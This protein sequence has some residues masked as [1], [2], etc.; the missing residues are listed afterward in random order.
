MEWRHSAT[1]LNGIRRT[2]SGEQERHGNHGGELGKLQS[3]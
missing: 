2:S 3:A 1:E